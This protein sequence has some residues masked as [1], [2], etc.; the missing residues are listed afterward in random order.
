[1]IIDKSRRMR[2]SLET[3]G[4]YLRLES[5]ISNRHSFAIALSSSANLELIGSIHSQQ[6]ERQLIDLIVL[7]CYSGHEL[8]VE[9][10]VHLWR[11]D[12]VSC[13]S[14]FEW[15]VIVPCCEVDFLFNLV[16]L[17]A[18]QIN[19]NLFAPSLVEDESVANFDLASLPSVEFFGDDPFPAVG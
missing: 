6:G 13:G 4:T 2:R 12:A 14:I 5:Y 3:W 11:F 18:I 19:N 17:F 16:I 1:M 9:V 15:E 10:D 7:S 8:V